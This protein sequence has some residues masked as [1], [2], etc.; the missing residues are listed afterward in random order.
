MTT[1]HID[2]LIDQITSSNPYVPADF[3]ELPPLG[4]LPTRAPSPALSGGRP[5]RRTASLVAVGVV[6]AVGLTIAALAPSSAPGGG[7]VLSRAFAQSA[8]T[9][10]I[11]HWR[12]TIDQ[13]GLPEATDEV[14]MHVRG[15]GTVDRLRQLRLDGQ[16]AGQEIATEQP[17][18]V[19][20]LHGAV[21]RDRTGPDA[22]VRTTQ[23]MGA[24]E[25][26]LAEIVAAAQKAAHGQLDVGA[27]REV[28]YG[29]HDAYEVTVRDASGAPDPELGHRY[30]GT[31]S[32]TVWLTRDNAYTPLAVRW[33]EGA[34]LFMTERIDSFERV[35]ANASHDRL[36]E[37]G[38][39]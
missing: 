18:G 27:A 28:T 22:P 23:G 36:L 1:Q 8:G 31:V 32:I 33:G 29:G 12:A 5:L 39:Q 24:G 7:E 14:W 30:P 13:P 3:A 11:L 38:G 21:T 6:A 17:N 26:G 15:D 34:D 2:P 37:L 16:H 20:D 10:D 9:A 25:P 19:G 35:P 4:P